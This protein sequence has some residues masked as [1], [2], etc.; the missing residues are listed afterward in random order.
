MPQQSYPKIGR[1]I[2]RERTVQK[3]L[4]KNE[5]GPQ[6]HKYF[7]ME[8]P[9]EKVPD[10]IR[11]FE[12]RSTDITRLAYNAVR[13]RKYN[14]DDPKDNALF[15]EIFNLVLLTSPDPYRPITLQESE[16]YFKEGT[17]LAFLYG[18]CVGYAVVTIE[19]DPDVGKIG[20]I[21]GIGVHPKFR[22]K[23][24]AQKLAIEIG[25]WFLSRKD[26]KKLQCEVYE[27][28]VVSQQFISSFGF[29]IVGEI[30]ID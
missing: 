8:V 4:Q 25:K 28:N 9:I 20:V 29:Q 22:R 1:L 3:I 27:E 21:A 5:L 26:L 23:K 2:H 14:A 6:K 15:T 13:V 7:L 30:F 16:K 10:S 17:F 11:D 12:K 19:N 24:V 18:K